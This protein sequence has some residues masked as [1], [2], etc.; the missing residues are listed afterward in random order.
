LGLLKAF[1]VRNDQVGV[2][3]SRSPMMTEV[4]VDLVE[5]VLFGDNLVGVTRSELLWSSLTRSG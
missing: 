2:T 4:G 1:E 3:R 5:E